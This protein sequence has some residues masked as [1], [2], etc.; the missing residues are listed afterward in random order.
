MR[1][2]KPVNQVVGAP[3]RPWLF[4]RLPVES[5]PGHWLHVLEAG[6]PDAP[7]L[8]LLHGAAGSWHN[9][10]LQI[11]WLQHGYRIISLDLRGHGLSP[12]PG[13]SH[14]EDFVQDVLG[15]I[16]ARIPGP[17]AMIGHSFGGC[18]ATLVADRM[19]ARARG[20]TQLNTAGEIPRGPL[21]RFLKL[22]ARFSHW[23]AQ[24][25]PYWIS[26]HGR[27]AHDLLWDT[28]PAWNTWGLYPKIQVPTMVV[29]G[30]RDSLIPWRSSQRMAELIPGATS[31]LIEDG[32]HVCMWEHPEI[33]RTQLEAWLS[34]LDWQA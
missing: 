13:T 31:H 15:V 16:D 17:F 10:R 20:L 11:E 3:P 19:G 23:V 12:W 25:E 18:L 22:F 9:F 28:L 14:I 26:C 7:T 1:I 4:T 21:F 34:R 8:L 6:L 32:A 27:V 33:L 2:T 29:A 5:P 24:I 30:K